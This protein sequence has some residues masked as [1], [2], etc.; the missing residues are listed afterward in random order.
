[1]VSLLPPQSDVTLPGPT[2]LEGE[3]QGDL[4]QAPGL[5]GSPAPQ[6]VSVWYPGPN[7][8]HVPLTPRG[9]PWVCLMPS[10]NKQVLQDCKIQRG[11]D[12]NLC[13]LWVSYQPWG[14]PGLG[15]VCPHQPSKD[16]R[17][18]LHC[19]G[20]PQSSA[21]GHFPQH[22][23]V[24]C[25]GTQPGPISTQGLS[26]LCLPRSMPVSAVHHSCPKAL[27]RGHPRCLHTAQALRHQVLSKSRV[28]VQLALARALFSSH[29]Q[30]SIL[31][32]ALRRVQQA[33]PGASSR[34]TTCLSTRTSGI[35]TKTSSQRRR[36]PWSLMDTL[37]RPQGPWRPL[38]RSLW[39]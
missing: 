38:R 39:T 19:F 18:L 28:T 23:V 29:P 8:G 30:T 11:S 25:Q 4:M 5:P 34:A 21:T 35:S 16:R 33:A 3:P 10:I 32:S 13:S 7:N 9:P 14:T 2:R 6:N 22:T 24:T 36:P 31:A 27:L 20:I 17:C 15:A 26:A 1:M 12:I 37:L